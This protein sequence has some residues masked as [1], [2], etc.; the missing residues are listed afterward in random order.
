MTDEDVFAP[1]RVFV[2]RVLATSA[3]RSDLDAA[4]RQLSDALGVVMTAPDAATAREW[5]TAA[6]APDTKR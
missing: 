6:L 4:A 1:G 2:E 5:F 3:S